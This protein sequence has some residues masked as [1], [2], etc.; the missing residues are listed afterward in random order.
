MYHPIEKDPWI[1]KKIYQFYKQHQVQTEIMLS[2]A[3]D[4][5]H[6]RRYHLTTNQIYWQNLKLMNEK[7]PA[8]STNGIVQ[9]EPSAAA[10]KA[11]T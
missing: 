8:L 1:V 4:Q 11:I 10:L 9:A 3:D 2:S 6:L 5:V 7:S